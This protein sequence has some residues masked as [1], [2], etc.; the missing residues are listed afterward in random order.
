LGASP[1]LI[2]GFQAVAALLAVLVF[3]QAILAGQFITG[4]R[5][6]VDVHEMLG[7]VIFLAAAAQ[8]VLAWL[9]RDSWR[10]KM[11]IWSAAVLVLVVAQIG[12]GYSG[13]DEPEVVA[14]HI[15]VGVFLFSFTSIIAMLSA[16]DERAREATRNQ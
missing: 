9:T 3:V 16:M 1:G 2:R 11:V 15:P 7:N 12:L 6:L 4:D 8:L 13:R 10:Y 14:I 5:D